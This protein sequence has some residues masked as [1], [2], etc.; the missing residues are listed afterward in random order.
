MK[1]TTYMKLDICNAGQRKKVEK[2]F[3]HKRVFFHLETVNS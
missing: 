1:F 3:Y 2:K